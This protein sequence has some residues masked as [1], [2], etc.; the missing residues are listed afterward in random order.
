MPSMAQPNQ[1]FN[2]GLDFNYTERRILRPLAH[3]PGA[4]GPEIS[5]FSFRLKTWG[6]SSAG[7]EHPLVDAVT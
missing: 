3:G 4:K 2:Q 1:G 6:P 7:Q 5:S